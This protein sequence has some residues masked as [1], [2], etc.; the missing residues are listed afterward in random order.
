MPH[1]I[2]VK[3]PK[4]PD[5]LFHAMGYGGLDCIMNYPYYSVRKPS[6]YFNCDIE[7]WR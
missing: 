7:I 2:D 4:N 6:H 3:I 5:G 1:G